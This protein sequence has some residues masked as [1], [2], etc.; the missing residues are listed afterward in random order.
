MDVARLIRL[1]PAFAG[2]A[3]AM[4]GYGQPPFPPGN[5]QPGYGQ[6]GYGQVYAPQDQPGAPTG[7]G[8]MPH[9][10]QQ[11]PGQQQYSGQQPAADAP[12]FPTQEDPHRR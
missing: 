6:Q 7:Y 4:P 2:S 5:G 9:G 10:Q 1:R 3:A 8:T 11:Y 12:W